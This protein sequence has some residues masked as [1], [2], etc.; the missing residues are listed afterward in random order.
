MF[1]VTPKLKAYLVEKHGVSADATDEAVLKSVADLLVSGAIE[2]SVIKSLTEADASGA[3]ERLQTMVSDTV[4]KALAP[5]VAQLGNLAQKP[6]ETVAPVVPGSAEKALAAAAGATGT[7]GV[8]VRVKSVKEQFNDSRTA[9]TWDKSANQYYAKQ[10]GGL[11]IDR[12]FEGLPYTIDMPTEFTKALTGAVFKHKALAAMKASGAAIPAHMQMKQVE[13]DLLNYAVHECRWIGGTKQ[14]DYE[15]EKLTELDRKNILD[16]SLSGGLEAVPIEFDSAVIL[17]PLLSGEVFPLVNVTNVSRRRIEAVKIANLNLTWGTASGTG[18]TPF[19]TD[20]LISSMDTNI[21]PLVAAIE[22]G[23]DFLADSPINIGSI[24]TNLYGEAF[25]KELDDTITYGNGTNRPEG[26]FI[27]SG[28]AT[29]SSAGGAGTDPQVGDY[30]GL[31]FGVGKQYLQEA[32]MGAGSRAAFVGSLTSYR[33]SRGIPVGTSDARRVFGMDHMSYRM[34][35]F[36]YAINES[37]GNAN[38]GFFCF[39]RYRL[40]RR[41]G[42][43]VIFVNGNT[44]FELAKRNTR[45]LVLRSRWGGQLELS[46]AGVKITDAKA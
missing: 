18:I 32:G 42:Q 4:N 23:E 30:E 21:Y 46:T 26:V 17:T 27:A 28:L 14:H 38:I 45:G 20:S 36:K 9:A 37:Q 40:Y 29:V 5:L 2:I 44:D 33:R 10:F 6:A 25:K 3:S 7:S 34:F 11:Q 24:V 1:Q 35:D 12:N 41:Q 16:D 22:M 31:I 8:E 13:I 15:G 43:E 19:N 39:N